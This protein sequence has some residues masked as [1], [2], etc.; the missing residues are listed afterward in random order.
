[1]VSW[2]HKKNTAAIVAT[3]MFSSNVKTKNALIS[4]KL[5]SLYTWHEL[6]LHAFKAMYRKDPMMR[7]LQTAHEIKT[8]TWCHLNLWV[9]RLYF[10]LLRFGR[11]FCRKTIL[12]F[13]GGNSAIFEVL[14]C[15][16]LRKYPFDSFRTSCSLCNEGILVV[17]VSTN[18][19]WIYRAC[20]TGPNLTL[21]S[22]PRNVVF[23]HHPRG[24]PGHAKGT[25]D[26]WWNHL[27]FGDQAPP[28]QTL[29]MGW[30]CS[31]VSR[32]KWLRIFVDFHRG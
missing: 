12:S 9:N 21:S 27:E 24:I 8:A 1:M 4:Q 23:H 2:N 25:R 17:E 13:V 20:Q 22:E 3:A 5:Q 30:V 7:W 10:S 15:K 31:R 6:D 14:F 19:P 16:N 32:L 18:F 28:K 29:E 26:A 11:P